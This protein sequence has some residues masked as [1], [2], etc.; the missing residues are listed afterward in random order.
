MP[1]TLHQALAGTERALCSGFGSP[2]AEPFAFL[3]P[4]PPPSLLAPCSTSPPPS[5][6]KPY[7]LLLRQVSRPPAPGTA[8]LQGLLRTLT[9]LTRSQVVSV[10]SSPRFTPINPWNIFFFFFKINWGLS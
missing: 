2:H 9:H 3:L 10:E 6:L 8:P 1:A 4:G 7:L 5:T